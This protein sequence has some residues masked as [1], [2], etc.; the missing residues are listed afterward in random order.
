MLLLVQAEKEQLT[1]FQNEIAE[2]KHS[3]VLEGLQ[4]D[5]DH[6][7]EL[8]TAG[9]RTKKPIEEMSGSSVLVNYFKSFC[10]I[11]LKKYSSIGL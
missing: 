6:F 8:Q 9:W 1:D 3:V 10:N 5:I 7:T 11:L 2:V 4:K